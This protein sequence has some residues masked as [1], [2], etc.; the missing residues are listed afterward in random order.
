M[1]FFVE[2]NPQSRMKIQSS[3]LHAMHTYLFRS[4][5]QPNME[6]SLNQTRVLLKPAR[7]N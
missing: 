5:E 7:R 1:I 3:M 2:H 4:L 6:V